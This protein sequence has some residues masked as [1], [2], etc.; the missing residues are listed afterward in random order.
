[1]GR[2]YNAE[3]IKKAAA[4]LR[5]VKDDPFLACDIITG[6]PGETEEEFNRTFSLCKKIDFAWIH[7]FPYSAR[8]GTAAFSFKDKVFET[9]VTERVRLLTDLA[10]KGK[11]DY[12]QRWLGREVDV[13]AEN[14]RK[15]NVFCGTSENYLKA[16]VQLNE[17]KSLKPGDVVRC[18]LLERGDPGDD[19]DVITSVCG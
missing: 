1:M 15:K 6:F 19:F 13:L 14:S 5:S 7:V 17:G 12:V 11:A 3:T 18:K 8:Q 2:D 16:A 9:D 4:L 10:K